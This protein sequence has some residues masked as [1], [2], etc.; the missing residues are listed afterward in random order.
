MTAPTQSFV[1]PPTAMRA[2]EDRLFWT[3]ADL[4]AAPAPNDVHLQAL[5]PRGVGENISPL[6][7]SL[8]DWDRNSRMSVCRN[9]RTDCL[10]CANKNNVF[11][12]LSMCHNYE[13]TVRCATIA[14]QV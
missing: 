12:R 2:D 5:Q 13:L 14:Y 6:R 11:D 4:I 10:S 8:D 1:C 3:C 7:M 9:E